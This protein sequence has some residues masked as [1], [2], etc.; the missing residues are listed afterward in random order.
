MAG[1]RGR[2]VCALCER[3]GRGACERVSRWGS[4]ERERRQERVERGCRCEGRGRVEVGVWAYGRG[5]CACASIACIVACLVRLRHA[6]WPPSPPTAPLLQPPPLSLTRPSV[7]LTPCTP[8]VCGGCRCL[9]DAK[10]G[11]N[12]QSKKGV[13]AR[14]MALACTPH[15]HTHSHNHC[16]YF[17]YELAIHTIHTIQLY[18]LY[19][20]YT[21]YT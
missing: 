1:R 8:C 4:A 14:A 20:L 10:A 11:V 5:G 19:M 6:P 9:I 15:K 13:G 16:N 21:I 17:S 12:V 7:S 3:G 18:K 2:R